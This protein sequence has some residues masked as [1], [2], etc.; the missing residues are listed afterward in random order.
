MNVIKVTTIGDQSRVELVSLA[1]SQSTMFPM[2]ME[3]EKLWRIYDIVA[4]ISLVK[5]EIWN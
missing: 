3:N 5:K 2:W 1:N 4:E